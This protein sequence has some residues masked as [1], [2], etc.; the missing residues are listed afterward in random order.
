MVTLY[1]DTL[2]DHFRHPRNY[3]DLVNPDISH[4]S[5]NPLCGDRIRIEVKL[6]DTIVREARFKGDACAICTA[7]ASLLTELILGTDLTTISDISNDRLIAALESDIKPTRL[8]CALLPLEALREGLIS[9]R[10]K[11]VQVRPQKGT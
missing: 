6:R 2:L 7:A 5:F 8:Q 4:E 9:H 1:S 10:G 11:T 3:G